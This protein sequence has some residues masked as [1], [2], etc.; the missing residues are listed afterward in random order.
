MERSALVLMN[1]GQGLTWYHLTP[2]ERP[3]VRQAQGSV[4]PLPFPE[5][6]ARRSWEF[7]R[8]LATLRHRDLTLAGE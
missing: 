4:P 6:E 5:A 2:G 8:L 7:A 1:P 3:S